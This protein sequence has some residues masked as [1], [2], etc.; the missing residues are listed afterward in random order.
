MAH[1]HEHNYH[2]HNHHHHAVPS[3]ELNSAFIIGIILNFT[4]VIIEV[5]VGIV[6]NSLSLLSDAGHNLA[7]VGTLALSLLAFR[8]MK[9]KSNERF[10]YGYK[11]TS[12]FVALINSVVLLVSIG[13]IV[14][15]AFQRLYKPEP[16]Q[17]STIAIVAGIGIIINGVSALLFM[18][19]KEKDLN[20]KSAYLHLLS[21]AAV[22]FGL[23]IGGIIIIY[24]G[25]YIIDSILSLVIAGVI[26]ASTWNLLRDSLRLSLDAVPTGISI[27]NIRNM[28]LKIK[29]VKDLHHI[30][31]WAISTNENA[32][33]AHLVLPE[34]TTNAEEAEIK[35]ILK[36]ELEHN[37]IHHITL[38]SEH[39]GE[40]CKE[41]KC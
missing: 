26:L 24:T 19:N 14:F 3:G 27:E 21:D 20:I 34:G 36:H 16:T 31:I 15:E 22:S 17:G 33:T 39:A 28:A 11:K 38:E 5:V 30:H 9:I 29:G 35:H 12:V 18:R 8:M 25:W 4:F 10:T 1:Q 37:N 7:D 40:A 23:V 6:N 2:D 41:E 13:A 32:L